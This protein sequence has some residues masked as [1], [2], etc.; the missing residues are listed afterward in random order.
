MVNS[1]ICNAC[2]TSF[3]KIH[4]CDR[5]CS[6][7]T[8][9]TPCTKSESK[10][11]STCNRWFLSEKYF[12]NNLTLKVKRNLVCHWW[13]V[14][15]NCSFRVTGYS[16]HECI[17]RL[18]NYCIKSNL[19]AIFATR[20]H[21]SIASNRFICHQTHVVSFEHITKLICAQRMCSR[22]ET[23][24]ALSVACKH[25]G[26]CTHVFWAEELVDHFIDSR[27]RSRPFADKI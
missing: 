17:K 24:D 1:Y 8:D 2:D 5:A 26:E 14:Q 15:R 22:C 13:Q 4:K 23:V 20:S 11:C 27:H 7:C 16:K 9:T 21:W 3:E 18:C 25:F 6:L 12:Q 19:S 10:Y